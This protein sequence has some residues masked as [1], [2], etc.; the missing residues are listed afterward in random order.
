M[1]PPKRIDEFDH[2]EF[3]VILAQAAGKFYAVAR[4][5]RGERIMEVSG[6][7][8]DYVKTEIKQRLNE[9]SQVFLG[10]SGAIN[11][12]RESLPGWFQI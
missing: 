2:R 7:S 5:S 4:N 9:E 6:K 11:P 8:P 12:L 1:V 3:H 10:I